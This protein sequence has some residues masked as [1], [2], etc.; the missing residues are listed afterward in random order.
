M[1]AV[2]NFKDKPQENYEIGLPHAGTWKVRLNSD[3][4]MYDESFGNA[5]CE[6]IEAE[7]SG[8]DG[9]PFKGSLNLA[10]YGFL[11]ISCDP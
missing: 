1:V 5:V 8:M 2:L 11:V 10:P 7:Q 6:N 4:S 9:L 3:S